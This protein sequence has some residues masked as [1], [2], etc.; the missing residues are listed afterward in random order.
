MCTE[1]PT[2]PKCNAWETASKGTYPRTKPPGQEPV[3]PASPWTHDPFQPLQPLG[4]NHC[5][6]FYHHK[7]VFPV[8]IMKYIL[9]PSASLCLSFCL[10]VEGWFGL[11]FVIAVLLNG[12]S[13]MCQALC[14]ETAYTKERPRKAGDP[15]GTCVFVP[16][17]AG[18]IPPVSHDD[19]P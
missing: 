3:L 4:D 11:C 16:M 5:P 1:T 18:V 14:Q 2:S 8:R 10:F 7:L 17:W 9:F 19:S 13:I 6:E 15:K 12:L